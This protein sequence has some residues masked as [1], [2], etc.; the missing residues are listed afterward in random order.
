MSPS[1]RA[2]LSPVFVA[3]F[4]IAVGCAKAD[5]DDCTKMAEHDYGILDQRNHM[6]DSEAGKKLLAE[7]KQKTID[8]CIGKMSKSAIEC[9]M[10]APEPA[11]MSKCDAK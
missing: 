8:A 4:L 5:K 9:H 3:S 1:I 7:F 2:A 6:S 10:K 11:D